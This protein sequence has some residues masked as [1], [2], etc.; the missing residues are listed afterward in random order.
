[1]TPEEI[2]RAIAAPE[3]VKLEN[4]FATGKDPGAALHAVFLC[5]WADLEVPDWAQR[6]F[7]RIYAAGLHGRLGPKDWFKPARTKAQA[8][9]YFR[10]LDAAPKVW[11][12]VREAKEPIGNELFEKVGKEL[13]IGGR[14]LVQ[15]LWNARSKPKSAKKRPT[16][17]NALKFSVPFF[18]SPLRSIARPN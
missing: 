7:R 9:R 16:Q 14:T 8:E 17:K 15:E 1:M 5:F 12:M 18:R 13:G 2:R 11:R 4:S 3:L 6:E 10:S